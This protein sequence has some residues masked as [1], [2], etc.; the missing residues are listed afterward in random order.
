MASRSTRM[1][2]ELYPA[3]T[4][5]TGPECTQWKTRCC[6]SRIRKV[7]TALPFVRELDSP[8]AAVPDVFQRGDAFAQ[9]CAHGAQGHGGIAANNAEVHVKSC[10][11]QGKPRGCNSGRAV[12]SVN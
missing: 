10:S 11:A 7:F 1:R 6:S 8:D 4:K 3:S 12:S 9:G 5:P 2:K